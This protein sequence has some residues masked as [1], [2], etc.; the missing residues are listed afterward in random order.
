MLSA[1]LPAGQVQ[2]EAVMEHRRHRAWVAHHAARA[3]DE[4]S[5]ASPATQWDSLYWH[6][7]R[8]VPGHCFMHSGAACAHLSTCC[9]LQTDALGFRLQ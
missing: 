5:P 8:D 6:M 9:E 1:R 7:L 4:V 3:E 2:M